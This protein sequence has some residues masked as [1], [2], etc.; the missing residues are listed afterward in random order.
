MPF[1]RNAVASVSRLLGMGRLPAEVG[2]K[3]FRRH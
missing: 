2:H 3:R 1:V